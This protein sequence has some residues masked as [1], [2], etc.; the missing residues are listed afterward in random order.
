MLQPAAGT[1]LLGAPVSSVV[2]VVMP[3]QDVPGLAGAALVERV[4][5]AVHGQPGDPARQQTAVSA[6]EDA[7]HGL[8]PV[9]E[10]GQLV[11]KIVEYVETESD[12]VR[13]GQVCERFDLS[14][15]SLQRLAA[16]RI[17]LSPK[18]LIQRRRLHEAAEL[19]ASA[20][21]LALARVAAGLGYADQSHF[22]RDFRTVT[23]LTP[24]AY[25]AEPR[26]A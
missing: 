4:R 11:N 9:D 3:L 15:R 10:E 19:L 25:A 26:D 2:D 8:L 5:T 24:G 1:V 21:P 16:K 14:E 13:V 23:G 18:W 20:K 12:V 17:G 22:T 7:L 6:V